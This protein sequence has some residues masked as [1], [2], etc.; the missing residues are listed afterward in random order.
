M[1][2]EQARSTDVDH[3][4]DLFALGALAYRALTGV[5]AFDARDPVGMLLQVLNEQP[6]D[7][8]LHADIPAEVSLVLAAALAKHRGSRYASAAQ[9]ALAFRAAANR[10]LPPSLRR[11][12]E[13]LLAERPWAR[14]PDAQ[15]PADQR[16]AG[17][18]LVGQG[19]ALVIHEEP[20]ATR[21]FVR[22]AVA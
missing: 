14:R 22:A 10:D 19:R 13:A 2:P 20:S 5:Q 3:R 12:A 1:S 16:G 4:T 17:P 11:H 6:L 7:P 9:M 18:R 8:A 21:P 15:G